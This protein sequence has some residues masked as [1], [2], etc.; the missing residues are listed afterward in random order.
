MPWP[1]FKS[2][3]STPTRD[4]RS[5]GKCRFSLKLRTAKL[6][7]ILRPLLSN[8]KTTDFCFHNTNL[9]SA[10]DLFQDII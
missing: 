6:Q 3:F 7:A 5:D 10:Y 2:H 9:A 4:W 8:I 1:A